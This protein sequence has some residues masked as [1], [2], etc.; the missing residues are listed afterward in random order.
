MLG[1]REIL[2]RDRCISVIRQGARGTRAASRPSSVMSTSAGKKIAVKKIR[3]I[4]EKLFRKMVCLCFRIDGNG[5]AI[6]AG[7]GVGQ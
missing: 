5:S 7:V 4:V 6:L 1:S 2:V 3:N